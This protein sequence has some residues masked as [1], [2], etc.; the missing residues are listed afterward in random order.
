LREFVAGVPRPA[1]THQMEIN[2]S[3]VVLLGGL[4]LCGAASLLAPAAGVATLAA[5]AGSALAGAGQALAPNIAA[6]IYSRLADWTNDKLRDKRKSAKNHDLRELVIM[7]IENVLDSVIGSKPGG[8][9]GVKLLK[10]YQAK[11]RDRNA[12]V[13]MDERFKGTWEQAVPQYFKARVEEFA[14]VKALTPDIW[15][16][17]LNEDYDALIKLHTLNNDQLVALD[18]AANALYNDLPK[19][20]VGTFRDALQHQ[21][22]VYVAVQTA[23][24]QEIWNGVSCVDM[25][26][27][28]LLVSSNSILSEI[29]SVGET[30]AAANLPAMKSLAE[31]FK[32]TGD[33]FRVLLWTIQFL[34]HDTIELLTEVSG[35]VKEVLKRQTEDRA[36]IL[37]I[38]A[39]QRAQQVAG[40]TLKPSLENRRLIEDARTSRDP[41]RRRAAYLASGNVDKARATHELV[42]GLRQVHPR[43]DRLQRVNDEFSDSMFEGDLLSAE[44]KR[45]EAI[46]FYERAVA[47]KAS[48]GF[49]IVAL[50]SAMMDRAM[51]TAADGQRW[52]VGGDRFA[53]SMRRV[54]NILI[55]LLEAGNTPSNPAYL[56]AVWAHAHLWFI[57]ARYGVANAIEESTRALMRADEAAPND[58]LTLRLLGRNFYMFSRDPGR[59]EPYFKRAID[60]DPGD[61]TQML[62]Y[63]LYLTGQTERTDDATAVFERCLDIDPDDP[64]VLE[65]FAFLL[66]RQPTNVA[67]AELMWEHALRV[68]PGHAVGWGR[69][70][71]FLSSLPAGEYRAEEVYKRGLANRPNDLDLW[72][73]YAILLERQPGREN[74]A[75]DTF[76][77]ALVLWP[78]SVE[79]KARSVMHK[80]V[81][82]VFVNPEQAGP[83][84]V[85]EAVRS[86]HP[87][88]LVAGRWL[89][90]LYAKLG[91]QEEALAQLKSLREHFGKSMWF[92]PQPRSIA[93]AVAAGHKFATWL[94]PLARVIGGEL[95]LSSL[96]RWEAW[97]VA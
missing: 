30:I 64:D 81:A 74:D 63:A 35:D 7:S 18:A 91:D 45:E 22:T 28:T 52:N 24:L 67:R 55:P 94:N 68:S 46:L 72:L 16:Y 84:F 85:N 50:A 42:R 13:A 37:Q 32:A 71:G 83:W 56:P 38:L 61:I 15:K 8:S 51:T 43:L 92:I 10:G 89:G 19:H 58:P 62:A 93:Q 33:E 17:F 5:V 39:N 2:K 12:D 87:Q 40:V 60:A 95:P 6:D 82:G 3:I 29:R 11:V 69:Y 41:E 80:I 77:R 88:L 86:K 78:N 66:S 14:S 31:E 47:L 20:L 49:A 96:E 25:K 34:S 70:G 23:I 36:L 73:A 27:D 26:V 53:E 65:A 44:G 48:D 97:T 21:P 1:Y 4:G 75:I 57:L 54:G 90:F 9:I 76:D 59:A 79:V